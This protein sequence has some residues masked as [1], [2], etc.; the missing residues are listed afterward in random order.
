MRGHFVH[1]VVRRNSQT[2]TQFAIPT[3]DSLHVKTPWANLYACGD[4]IGYPTPSFWLERSTIT[5]IAAANFVLSANGSDP[6][7]IL[8]PSRPERLVRILAILLRIFRKLLAPPFR[9]LARLRR[10]VRVP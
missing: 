5:G 3:A 8:P 4:W 2:Q 1:G 6:Y 7:P 10:R 9:A